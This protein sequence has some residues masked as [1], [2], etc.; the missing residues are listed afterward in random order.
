MSDGRS[1][2]HSRPRLKAAKRA[3]PGVQ[4]ERAGRSHGGKV[5][6]RGHQR[7]LAQD[8]GAADLN[9][10]R[11]RA[12]SGDKEAVSALRQREQ[13]AKKTA[14]QKTAMIGQL[15]GLRQQRET[16]INSTEYKDLQR[17]RDL[18]GELSE[19]QLK[20]LASYD[21]QHKN[22]GRAV[23][24][25]EG[26]IYDISAK[27][28]LESTAASGS[29]D[30][31]FRGF[32]KEEGEHAGMFE[33]RARE[34]ASAAE[35]AA[36][37]KL[38]AEWRAREKQRTERNPRQPEQPQPKQT[39][40]G[41][42]QAAPAKD[43]AFGTNADGFVT[44]T[45]GHPIHFGH[46]R[47]AGWWIL[48]K[49]NK[50]SSNQV[51]EIANH[52]SGKGFTVR[53]THKTEGPGTGG[54]QEGG[55][56]KQEGPGGPVAVR[57][58]EPRPEGKTN[59]QAEASKPEVMAAARKVGDSKVVGK[60]PVRERARPV[61]DL[62]TTLRSYGGINP[63]YRADITG[64][65]KGAYG[66]LFRKGGMGLDEVAQRM[67]EDGFLD[68]T[69]MEDP[70]SHP[71]DHAAELIR[72]ALNGERILNAEDQIAAHGREQAADYRDNLLSKWP[73]RAS[74]SR[75]IRAS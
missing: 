50:Q 57:G 43:G 12:A 11:E 56:P 15:Q 31:P 4:A 51:F 9:A 46:Q 63:L 58:D 2:V 73:K 21:S 16:L 6:I 22:L 23:F 18:G 26:K 68:N 35:K 19:K 65:N 67:Y 29:G 72:R 24:D 55:G 10:L 5:R 33:A 49:G 17:T 53:E 25:L 48:K 62:L 32:S 30:R 28:D 37:D 20:K 61:R 39:E 40:A 1:R 7:Q 44:S 38:E 42:D 14:K 13:V 34:K 52:P 27:S 74:S 45:N 75:R 3:K 8:Q 64:E 70:N 69:H 60:K 36:I 54:K 41:T 71:G 59:Q 66:N 47:D